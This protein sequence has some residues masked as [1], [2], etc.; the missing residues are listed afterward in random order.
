MAELDDTLLAAKARGKETATL[1]A[2]DMMGRTFGM[3]RGRA[4][5]KDKVA[6]TGP[7]LAELHGRPDRAVE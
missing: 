5:K 6:A 2:L 7:S 4:S 1:R 3:W